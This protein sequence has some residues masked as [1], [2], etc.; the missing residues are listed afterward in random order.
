LDKAVASLLPR[1]QRQPRG[2]SWN[3]GWLDRD[4][5]V[6][7]EPVD[8]D[9]IEAMADTTWQRHDRFVR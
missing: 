3:W 1:R 5:S 6:L 2:R 7:H 9:A 4:D 8:E